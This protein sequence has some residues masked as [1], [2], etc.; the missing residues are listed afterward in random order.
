MS[1]LRLAAA[2][3]R[4]YL[5][6]PRK[7]K[8]CGGVTDFWGRQWASAH[9]FFKRRVTANR[10]GIRHRP[11]SKKVLALFELLAAWMG[12]RK[13]KTREASGIQLRA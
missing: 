9:C 3:R 5:W 2:A 4:V 13:G 10:P 1:S 7:L 8:K 6:T 11:S 12:D